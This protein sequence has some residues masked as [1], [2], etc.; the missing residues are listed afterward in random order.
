M[1]KKAQI[2]FF[3]LKIGVGMVLGGILAICIRTI[4]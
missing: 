3:F 4:I 2:E 1:S